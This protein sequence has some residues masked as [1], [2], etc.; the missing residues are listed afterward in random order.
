MPSTLTL[1]L[2]HAFDLTAAVCS[3][4]FY[5]LAPN[6]WDAATCTLRCPLR[7]DGDRIVTVTVRTHGDCLR[8]RCD[9]TLAAAERPMI[10]GQVARMLRLDEDFTGWFTRHR[11]AR[12][13]RFARLFRSPTLF[14]DIVK[15]FTCCNV[16]WKNTLTMNRLLCEHHGGGA[17]PTPPE[18]A[19][20]SEATLKRT[21]K[22]G[23]RAGRIVKLARDFADG[24]LHDGMFED[25]S[26]TT[27]EL[28]DR[29]RRVH[30]VGP[31]AAGNLC[32]LLGRYDR[33]AIDSETYRHFCQVERI[34]RPKNPATLHDRIEARYAPYEPYQFLA[35]WY[36]L[37]HD[38]RIE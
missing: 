6:N 35:Y 31:Y 18:L 13:R 37:W 20:V 14:E 24:R 8:V 1:P 34:D 4:G 16:T 19:K 15:T 3:Y 38:C 32:Q 21:C 2:P 27:G 29:L 17:F 36:E 33:L 9:T 12:R 30:G 11:Q 10:R 22:V 26:L 25:P 23:Y 7:G 5:V 28:F